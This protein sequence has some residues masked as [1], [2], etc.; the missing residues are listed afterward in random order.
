[1]TFLGLELDN[2]DLD[3]FLQLLSQEDTEKNIIEINLSRREFL[4]R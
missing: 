3:S 4:Y 2:Q 1:M